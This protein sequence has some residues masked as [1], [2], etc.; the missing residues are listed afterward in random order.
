MGKSLAEAFPE[1]MRV[2][3]DADAAL[4]FP[5]SRLCFEGPEDQLKL[6]ENTQPA[7][8]TVS[9]AA[10]A[11]LRSKGVAADRVAGHSLGEYSALVAAGSLDFADAVR[12][13]RKRG[14]YMQQAVPSGAGAMAALL[15]LPEDK[16][17]GILAEAAQGEVVTAAN[18]N[19]PDQ[20]VIAGN[21][22]AVERAM[23][24]AKAAGARRAVLLPVS[25]PFHCPLMKPAQERLKADLDA[26]RFRDLA[27]PLI[28][29][30][31]AREIRTGAEARDGL[32]QQV[33]NPVRWA[34]SIRALAQAG[35]TRFIEVGAGQRTYRV[36]PQYRPGSRGSEIW[37][38]VRL[39]ETRNPGGG[40][41]KLPHMNRLLPALLCVF[42][43]LSGCGRSAPAS[44]AATVNGRAITY[45][46]LDKLYQTNFGGSNET[47]G[48]HPG[49]DQTTYQRLQILRTLIDNEIMLQRAEKE[50]LLAVDA[51]VEAKFAELRAPYTQEEFQKQI[52]DRKMTAE[53]VKAQLRKELSV[54]KLIN[55]E[56]TSRITITDKEITDFY[57]ANKSSFNRAEPMIHMAQILVTP[58]PDPNVRNLKN[59]KAQ[60][61]GQARKKIE[62]LYQ[63]L[64]QGEDFSPAGAKLFRR[65]QLGA[66]R[67]RFGL[68]RRVRNWRRPTR[69]CA[70]Q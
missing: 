27:V 64:Q 42:A 59:D 45:S 56:T 66:K 61:E 9:I 35:V 11:V 51:D 26:T 12:L 58:H 50:G 68:H 70:R 54:E 5:L 39:G 44:V 1:A 10:D 52:A 43:A 2:F 38:G 4:G 46:E 60:D 17:A 18:L 21:T 13:V 28:N 23:E 49:D 34:D 62:R 57:N 19:S 6:T 32:Y 41:I 24:L 48:S 37:R 69:T 8:L 47:A 31:Q 67:R 65:S 20:I 40:R 29:N 14:Q 7:L 15:K 16:L 33:P 22:A 36:A 30:W 25:A 3:E 63:M 55:K 53:D